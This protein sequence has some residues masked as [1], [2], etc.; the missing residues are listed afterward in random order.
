MCTHSFILPA[1]ITFI[2]E[3]YWKP[4]S[5]LNVVAF[6]CNSSTQEAETKGSGVQGQPQLH[7]EFG[8]S[9][10]YVKPYL[11]KNKF[12]AGY[13]R[14]CLNLSAQKAMADKAL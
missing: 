2:R 8:D 7:R 11:N 10:G 4:R 6:T 12:I 13:G 14:K 5:V 1:L 9:L 3:L